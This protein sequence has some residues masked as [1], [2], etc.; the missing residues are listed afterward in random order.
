MAVREISLATGATA[1]IRAPTE[2][3]GR[4]AVPAPDVRPE[5]FL[6]SAPASLRG[7]WQRGECW[8]AFAGS[9]ARI[10]SGGDGPARGAN[11]F[12]EVRRSAEALF[13]RAG[14]R[15]GEGPGGPPRL[16]GGFGFS[17]RPVRDP[18]WAG[19]PAAR[20]ELPALEL[21]HDGREAWLIASAPGAGRGAS[22]DATGATD[23]AGAR[24]ESARRRLSRASSEAAG[25]AGERPEGVLRVRETVTRA[26]WRRGVESAL[27]EIRYGDLD[28]VV[29]ARALDLVTGISDPL[30]SFLRLRARNPGSHPF[31]FQPGPGAAFLSVAPELLGA[32]RGSRF[33]ATAVAGTIRRGRDRAEDERLARRLRESAKERTEHAIGVRDMRQR[34]EEVAGGAR[35]DAEPRVLRLRGIQHLRTDVR[36][37]LE[38]ERHILTL[39]GALHPTAAV[40]GYP[41]GP[42][43]DFLR[44]HES[45]ERGWYAGP[46]G[47]F[48]ARGDGEFAPG[49]RSAV[50]REGRARLFA[51]AGLVEGSEAE[52]EWEETGIKFVPVREALEGEPDS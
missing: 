33:H 44:E 15:T 45:F 22:D 32:R 19:F 27:R 40:C 34:L 36:A 12:D 4:V 24:L 35:V 18:L 11:P 31:F 26:E 51:G 38:E 16:Y 42:A 46:V 3:L 47:W 39:A 23:A 43:L 9:A 30:A 21:R 17:A 25:G 14:D 52:A 48:D 5:V 28:K 29:L 7:F 37:H 6:R 13:G 8:A 2:A 10:E 1:S 20:F 41:A 49:L 50:F